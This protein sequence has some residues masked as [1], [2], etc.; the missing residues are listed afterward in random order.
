MG[1]HSDI[2]VRMKSYYEE[3]A[4]TRLT[5]RTPVNYSCGW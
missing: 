3:V 1:L 2:E 5:R 4:K